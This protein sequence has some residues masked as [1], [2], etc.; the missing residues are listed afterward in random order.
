MYL[1]GMQYQDSIWRKVVNALGGA[2][3]DVA[4]YP[5][6]ARFLEEAPTLARQEEFIAAI[7]GCL[8]APEIERIPRRK[9]GGASKEPENF[10]GTGSLSLAVELIEALAHGDAWFPRSD[11]ADEKGEQ[12]RYYRRL[13]KKL[14]SAATA[15]RTS[16]EVLRNAVKELFSDLR[17][18]L[19]AYNYKASTGE[20]KMTANHIK[21]LRNVE[22]YAREV[23]KL[24]KN[25]ESNREYVGLI[26]GRTIDREPPEAYSL[27]NGHRCRP[28]WLFNFSRHYGRFHGLKRFVPEVTR[29]IDNFES[30]REDAGLILGDSDPLEAQAL[31][32]GGHCLYSWLLNFSR[33]YDRFH[34]DEKDA[35]PNPGFLHNKNKGF[36]KDGKSTEKTVA[37]F[38][39]EIDPRTGPYADWIAFSRGP[40]NKDFSEDGK[41]AEK[42]IDEFLVEIYQ[43]DGPYADWIAFSR[44]PAK[45]AGAF[46]ETLEVV[47]SREEENDSLKDRIL[48]P[49]E[50]E[51]EE[52]DEPDGPPATPGNYFFEEEEIEEEDPRILVDSESDIEETEN[53]NPD[54]DKEPVVLDEHYGPCLRRHP[55][56]VQVGLLLFKAGHKKFENLVQQVFEEMGVFDELNRMN[57]DQKE[58]SISTTKKK[59]GYA[60]LARW[61]GREK[62]QEISS[63]AFQAE[64]KRAL[65]KFTECI[66][67]L[68]MERS[69]TNRNGDRI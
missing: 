59:D 26:L 8:Y 12:G 3:L 34:P 49:P 29:L 67:R 42:T 57:D 48:P 2:V 43:S 68:A 10:L 39:A 63:A 35:P 4:A 64:I 60:T 7:L 19:D 9:S 21:N 62:G 30:N 65:K 51:R 28:E 41:S 24:I 15:G 18:E 31:L 46:L 25:W 66:K 58:V 55:K 50:L 44:G 16:A 22:R 61:F 11:K 17:D 1:Q 36:C 6:F 27:I 5:D 54:R 45:D 56:P 38:L 23:E 47:R 69:M 13:I 40:A 14:R 20:K 32:K 33:H 37:E 53:S 52:N